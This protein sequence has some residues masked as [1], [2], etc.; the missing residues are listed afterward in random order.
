M[1]RHTISVGWN[2][3]LSL[4]PSFESSLPAATLT[5]QRRRV[6]KELI[7]GAIPFRNYQVKDALEKLTQ[8]HRYD[9]MFVVAAER[10][11][12]P[13]LFQFQAQVLYGKDLKKPAGAN[14]L[15]PH[16]LNE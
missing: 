9:R 1:D 5:V 2:S 3:I 7:V 6:R 4:T 14:Q 16:V 15:A 12:L 11:P 13:T 10:T 8:I